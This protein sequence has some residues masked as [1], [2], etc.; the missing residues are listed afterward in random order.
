MLVEACVETATQ[1]A[2]A[3]SGADRVELCRQL[4]VGGLTPGLDDI[5][6]TRAALHIPLHV[7]I[8]PRA[9]PF[10]YSPG[11]IDAM[12]DAISAAKA[13]GADGVVIGA[14]T[15]SGGIDDAAMRRLLALSRP[16]SVTF[17]RAFDEIADQPAAVAALGTLGVN[18]V[19]TSG[20]MP[21]ALAGA[22]RLRALVEA[23]AGRLA[24]MA[25]GSV[26]PENVAELVRRSGVAEVHA[27]MDDAPGR[28]GELKRQILLGR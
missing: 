10:G 3:A 23:A 4:D 18:R 16:L 5:V 17:H 6:A 19:L 20:G 24:V 9:G 8:R 21:T 28:A 2:A 1:A 15:P 27:R 26:R 25:G 7:L 22:D 14:L 12:A 11:E 13:A